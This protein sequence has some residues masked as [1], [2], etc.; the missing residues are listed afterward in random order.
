M[1]E[2]EIVIEIE[3]EEK[4]LNFNFVKVSSDSKWY[5]DRFLLFLFSIAMFFLIGTGVAVLVVYLI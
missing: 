1:S 4:P 5:R 3:G 2:G